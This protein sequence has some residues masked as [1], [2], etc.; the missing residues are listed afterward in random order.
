VYG[1]RARGKTTCARYL[2]EHCVGTF[3][4]RRVYV[5][6]GI[7]ADYEWRPFL[8]KLNAQRKK[9][10]VIAFMAA[11]HT[12]VGAT[13]V[14]Q[15]MPHFIGNDIGEMIMR[16]FEPNESVKC[17]T[18]IP[19]ETGLSRTLSVS[20]IDGDYNAW[21]V[22][23]RMNCGGHM[24]E[25]IILTRNH[26]D[27]KQGAGVFRNIVDYVVLLTHDG[28]RNLYWIL[29]NIWRITVF[30]SPTDFVDVF[31]KCTENRG[32]MVLDLKQNKVYWMKTD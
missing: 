16:D 18:E 26:F 8:Q 12:R 17:T 1:D 15:Q 29:L 24:R 6:S 10:R 30:E 13:S 7:S 28:S 14:L 4:D 20:V 32:A 11:W 19:M 23:P 5:D 25:T 9:M 21:M 22:I 27:F 3:A 31:G 2:C